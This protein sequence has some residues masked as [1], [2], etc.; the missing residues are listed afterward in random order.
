M[1]PNPAP[2]AHKVMRSPSEMTTQAAA[3]TPTNRDHTQV[4]RYPGTALSVQSKG[5][6]MAK[7]SWH[8]AWQLQGNGGWGTVMKASSLTETKIS[9]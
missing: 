2:G 4:F 6:L 1:Y 9:D 8:L 5:F 7:T 3:F